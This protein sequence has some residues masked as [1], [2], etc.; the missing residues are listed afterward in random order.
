MK[1]T[2]N[3]E[4]HNIWSA[5][6]YILNTN[7]FMTGEGMLIKSSNK[8]CSNGEYSLYMI[9]ISNENYFLDTTHLKDVNVGDTIN[10]KVMIYTPNTPVNVR[11]RG[12]YENLASVRVPPSN[13]PVEVSLSSIIPEEYDYMCLR[14]L[15]LNIN[16]ECFIDDVVSTIN[17]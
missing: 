1:D 7:G 5:T 8:W 12:H 17:Q 10:Y 15:P 6:D 2:N 13:K 9:K 14:F 3:L 11:I 16:G 4:N